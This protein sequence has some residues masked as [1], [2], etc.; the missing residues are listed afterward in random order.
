[1][2]KKY[3]ELNKDKIKEY[4]RNYAKEHYISKVVK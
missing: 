1:M 4:N 2:Q 3:R